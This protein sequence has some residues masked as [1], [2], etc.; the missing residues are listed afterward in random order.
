SLCG[1]QNEGRETLIIRAC[2]EEIYKCPMSRCE[3]LDMVYLVDKKRKTRLRWFWDVKMRGV[4]APTRGVKG[5]QWRASGEV[6]AG[7]RSNIEFIWKIQG[8]EKLFDKARVTL[9]SVNNFGHIH[10]LKVSNF[11]SSTLVMAC[12]YRSISYE[13]LDNPSLWA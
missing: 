6:E 8:E 13:S 4:D 7:Q 12:E 1:G 11:E 2:E 10:D 5:W 9:D 3:R